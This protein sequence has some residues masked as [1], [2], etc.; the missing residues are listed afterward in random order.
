MRGPVRGPV[1]S[2]VTSAGALRAAPRTILL[3]CLALSLA[4]VAGDAEAQALAGTWESEAGRDGRIHLQLRVER[5]GRGRSSNGFMVEASALT[6]D[7]AAA[8]G[9]VRDA[10]FELAREA[11]TFSF[12]GEI[13][14]GRGDGTFTFA[15]SE[16]YL[17]AMAGL[18]F[19]EL[20]AERLFLFA[21]LDVTTDYVR[22]LGQLGYGALQLEEL[23][24][25]AIHRV[26]VDYIRALNGLGYASIPPEQLVKLRIHGVSPEYARAMRAALGGR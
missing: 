17:R 13:R 7:D 2:P 1:R 19:A 12:S 23:T 21:A 14:D 26:S 22:E 16:A 25:L 4:L 10:R 3:C 8:R 20:S 6:G 15:P 9:D 5:E 24:G 11:G 18:G